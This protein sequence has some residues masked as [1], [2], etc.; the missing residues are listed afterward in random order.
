[1]RPGD[2]LTVAA[3]VASLQRSQWRSTEEIRRRQLAALDETLAFALKRV[4]HYR[5]AG[6][7]AVPGDPREQ[8][9]R[10]P[11]LTKRVLQAAGVSMLAEG[12]DEASAFR[13]RTSGSTGEP[14]VTWFDRRTWLQAR[15]AHKLRRM[16]AYGLGPGSGVVIVSEAD[17]AQLDQH[18]KSRLA[19]AGWLFRQEFLS[20]RTPLARHVD[21]IL[22]LE[23]DALYAFP[24]YLA[25]FLDHCER[26]G[27]E[28]P[29][30][31]VVF[32]SSEM[33]APSLRRR[34]AERF[35]A[36]VCD[37]YGCTE[38]KEVA[39]QCAAGTYHVNHESVW[40]ECEPPARAGEPGH[41]LLTTLVNRAGPLIRYRVGDLGRLQSVGCDCGR[42]GPALTDLEGR[43][44]DMLQ[45][46][47]G[48]RFS[49]YVLTTAI[50]DVPGLGQ[51]Q[52]VQTS[53]D[54]LELRYIALDGSPVDQALLVSRIAR[55]FG[56]GLQVTAKRVPEILRTPGGKRSVLV[57]EGAAGAAAG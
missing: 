24:S 41:L 33:L 43:E 44:G 38:F 46:R 57:R 22:R 34:L 30:L 32:T 1:M 49:P 47:D 15:Y 18:R 19:G 27:I 31:K 6:I 55:L 52:F 10:F 5:S 50:E 39:W 2:F 29:R 54:G 26:E 17:A 36:R 56:D 45:L 20:I 51:Y 9:S 13:S 40:V 12:V 48:R 42:E 28:L 8:L 14:T 53:A 23:P 11:V 16:L 37:I 21:E 4:P 3:S 7:E 35:R 25:D